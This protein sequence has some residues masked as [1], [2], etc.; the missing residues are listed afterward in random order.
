MGNF[1]ASKVTVDYLDSDD[2]ILD[3]D[4]YTFTNNGSVWDEW[5]YGYGDFTDSV[6]KVVYT[7]IKRIGVN[8]RVTFEGTDSSPNTYCGFLVA[9]LEVF[10]GDT[11]DKVSFP[12]KRI[13]K[14][15]V[16]VATFNTILPK[17][18]LMRRMYDAKSNI[19]EVML[20]VIDERESSSHDNMVILGKITKCDGVGE[21]SPVNVI[22]W[23][24]EQNI[25]K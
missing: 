1:K 18:E 10:M 23:Q 7:H 11:L 5:T 25:I 12:D 19:N 20:F 15:T 16:S 14:R 24:V 6:S 3:S 22:S 17:Q 13:G 8:I 4:V 2:N 21:K 9:G